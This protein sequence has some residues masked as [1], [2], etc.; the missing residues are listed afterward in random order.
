[1]KNTKPNHNFLFENFT[2]ILSKIF[3]N[4]TVI[5]SGIVIIFVWAISGPFFGYSEIWQLA[6]NGIIL[7]V[8]LIHKMQSKN[9]LDIQLK[10]NE[11]VAS[12][13]YSSNHL[14]KVRRST[15]KENSIVQ[16]YYQAIAEIAQKEALNRNA[17][18]T[19]EKVE[20]KTA[21]NKNIRL[22]EG[23]TIY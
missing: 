16:N 14:N 23:Q 6:I 2:Q 10:L 3:G 7:L 19:T 22:L 13:E 20:I 1:M 8:V 18:P 11:L 4:T 21:K 17:N 5:I 12:N 9:S 15:E